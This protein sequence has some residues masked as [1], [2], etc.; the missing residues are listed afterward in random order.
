MIFT[1]QQLIELEL[2]NLAQDISIYYF[3]NLFIKHIN[4]F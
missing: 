4:P 1:I 2:S 3:F